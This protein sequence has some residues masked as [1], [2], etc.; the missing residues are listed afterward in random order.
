MVLSRSCKRKAN[1][2]KANAQARLLVR[3]K[4]IIRPACQGHKTPYPVYIPPAYIAES[5]VIRKGSSHFT[6]GL[7]AKYPCKEGEV[8]GD[9]KGEVRYEKRSDV[10]DGAASHSLTIDNHWLYVIDGSVHRDKNG[11]LMDTAY[12][13]IMICAMAQRP[14]QIPA[15]IRT[16]GWS[17]TLRMTPLGS[18]VGAAPLRC[19]RLRW[20]TEW[21]RPPTDTSTPSSPAASSPTGRSPPTRS[22]SSTTGS[23]MLLRAL[24]LLLCKLAW[25]HVQTTTLAGLSRCFL[26]VN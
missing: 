18:S 24:A 8:V 16:A 13:T 20:T 15:R 5:K 11:K 2:A 3:G 10:P 23:R 6:R 21:R 7:F 17:G 14:L 26:G 1:K 19:G 4:F 12:Y 9:Y 22:T 25:K